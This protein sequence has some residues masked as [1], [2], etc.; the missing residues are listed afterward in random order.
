MFPR[1]FGFN[2]SDSVVLPP[3][4]LE[5]PV[6]ELEAPPDLPLELETS[7]AAAGSAARIARAAAANGRRI[8]DT[9]AKRTP[10]IS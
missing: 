9:R 8:G 7:V 10:P 5:L 1:L 2:V 4:V 3:V 6:D